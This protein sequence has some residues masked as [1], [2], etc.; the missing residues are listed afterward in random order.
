[1]FSKQGIS[2]LFITIINIIIIPL[3]V[4]HREKKGEIFSP[5]SGGGQAVA[6]GWGG[7]AVLGVGVGV[8]ADSLCDSSLFKPRSIFTSHLTVQPLSEQ[9]S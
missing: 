6:V 1:M 3:L 2:R 5:E 7:G 4:F 8:E 9:Y